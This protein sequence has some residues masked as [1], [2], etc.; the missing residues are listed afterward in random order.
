MGIIYKINFRDRILLYWRYLPVVFRMNAKITAVNR[1]KTLIFIG[2]FLPPQ[3]LKINF[4][5]VKVCSGYLSWLGGG[6]TDHGWGRG[7]NCFACYLIGVTWI[8]KTC[9]GSYYTLCFYFLLFYLK[10]KSNQTKI[11]QFASRNFP[12]QC[13][14]ALIYST[15]TGARAPVSAASPVSMEIRPGS[16]FTCVEVKG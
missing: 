8:A 12:K 14:S 11:K 6:A 2:C 5:K 4:S 13:S 7:L 15:S 10:I 1:T 3:G 9:D 16:G